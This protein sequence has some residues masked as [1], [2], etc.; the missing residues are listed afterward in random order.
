M[1]QESLGAR[2]ARYRKAKNMTQEELASQLN[3][4]AQAVS[5]W[6]NDLSAPD[7][8]ILTKL[9]DLL[10]ISLDTLLRDDGDIPVVPTF[11]APSSS[12]SMMIRIDFDSSDGD[13][14]RVRIPLRL[15][16]VCLACG[17]NP[18]NIGD[19]HAADL[20]W[21]QILALIDSGI[22][23]ELVSITSSDGDHVSVSVG[24]CES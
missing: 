14:G 3:L 12:E 7:V 19:S 22:V 20:D 10:G 4:T 16:R 15:V 1:N 2:I 23:G 11:T 18:A 5:K 6:E 8:S 21:N 9:S 24:P 13:R 17:M